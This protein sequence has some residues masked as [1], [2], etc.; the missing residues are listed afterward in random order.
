MLSEFLSD[1]LSIALLPV[2]I[3]D[4]STPDKAGFKNLDRSSSL[5]LMKRYPIFSLLYRMPL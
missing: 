3:W 1:A 4:L 2:V 5:D